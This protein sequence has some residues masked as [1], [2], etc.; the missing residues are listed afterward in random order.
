MIN[1]QKLL[2]ISELA[3]EFSVTARTIRFYEDKDLLNPQ[4]VGANR[5][6]DY[7]DRARLI[8]ILR[9][10]R[11]GFSLTDIREYLELYDADPNQREQH[12]VLLGKIQ[13]RLQ[14]LKQQQEDLKVSIE[15][16]KDI[17]GQCLQH[18]DKIG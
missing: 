18:L 12:Q 6:Y 11:L 15:E 7:R 4:R 9:A 8:L 2:T 1:I 10:K 13:H 16:L 17:E 14:D 3:D 5:V